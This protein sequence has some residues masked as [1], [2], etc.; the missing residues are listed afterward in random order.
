M[1]MGMSDENSSV[2]PSDAAV[3]ALFLAELRTAD[4]G[5][6]TGPFIANRHV[7]A[8]LVWPLEVDR[9][10]EG[11]PGPRAGSALAREHT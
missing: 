6:A 5:T 8:L 7:P 9:S 10:A 4:S 3:P 2:S 1:E 11:P